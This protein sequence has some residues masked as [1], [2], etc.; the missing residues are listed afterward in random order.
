MLLKQFKVF[1]WLQGTHNFVKQS[2]YSE[3]P[4]LKLNIKWKDK[5]MNKKLR[6]LTCDLVLLPSFHSISVERFAVA[7]TDFFGPQKRICFTEKFLPPLPKTYHIL[8]WDEWQNRKRYKH[9]TNWFKWHGMWV[10]SRNCSC[11]IT[12]FCYHLIAKPGNKTTAVPWPAPYE[13]HQLPGAQT[14]NTFLHL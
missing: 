7:L 10:R 1:V 4:N 5:R 3:I 9:I 13:Q 11:L 8:K 2:H 12:W 6:N 14:T